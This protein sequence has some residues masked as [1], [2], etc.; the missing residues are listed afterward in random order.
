MTNKIFTTVF[1]IFVVLSASAVYAKPVRP[2]PKVQRVTINLTYL[3]YRPE[4]FRLRRGIRAF[5]TFIRRTKDDC[6]EVIV[7]PAYSIRRTLPFN[8][9]LTV[10]F[11]PRRN[12]TFNFMC[13]MDMLRGQIIVN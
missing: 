4:S 9:P 12:G 10:S 3:G 8:Q 2:R 5:V 1:A 7:I 13:G 11:T 6:G